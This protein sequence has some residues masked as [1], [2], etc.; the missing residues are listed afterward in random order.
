MDQESRMNRIFLVRPTKKTPITI[1]EPS[2]RQISENLNREINQMMNF[3]CADMMDG[4]GSLLLC[5]NSVN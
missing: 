2:S 5:H 4:T 3:R 1:E